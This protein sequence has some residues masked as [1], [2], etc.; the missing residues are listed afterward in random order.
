MG[1][2]SLYMIVSKEKERGLFHKNTLFGQ[3]AM[4]IPVECLFVGKN[5]R[6]L[7]SLQVQTM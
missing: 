1:I 7:L 4:N 5:S 6:T 2:A 3:G